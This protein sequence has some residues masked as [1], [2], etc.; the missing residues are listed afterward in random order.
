ME[1]RETGWGCLGIAKEVMPRKE[2][3]R[4]AWGSWGS[5]PGIGTP[6]AAELAEDDPVTGPWV[7]IAF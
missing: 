5:P 7:V 6:G 1:Q 4:Q 2:M 3:L